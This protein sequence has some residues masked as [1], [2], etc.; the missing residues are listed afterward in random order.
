M[1]VRRGLALCMDLVRKKQFPLST[2]GP[3]IHNNDVI[4]ELQALG[5]SSVKNADDL[6]KD[7]HILI[8]SHGV[9]P[10]QRKELQDKGLNI[11][12][13]TCPKVAKVQ[14][15]IKGHV[16]KGYHVVI[17]GDHGHA[18]T[19]GLIGYANDCGVIIP[20]REEAETF[21]KSKD[22]NTPICVVAQTTQ[23]LHFF[24]ELCDLLKTK[25]N[26]LVVINTICD[27]T[28]GRQEEIRKLADDFD[29][30][31]VVGS[32]H[33]AN[34]TR[35]YEIAK[36]TGKIAHHVENADELEGEVI[37][38]DER[39][40]ITAGASTPLWIIYDIKNRLSRDSFFN[41]VVNITG[42]KYLFL[43]LFMLSALFAIFTSNYMD[44]LLLLS[45]GLVSRGVFALFNMK[46]DILKV[47]NNKL[48]LFFGFAILFS[49]LFF[50]SFNLIYL[51]FYYAALISM[52]YKYS[53]I[54]RDVIYTLCSLV[55][56][57]FP[58][59]L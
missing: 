35:L 43:A 53:T 46:T 45:V 39:V 58:I 56:F 19:I 20:S 10:T 18:E 47:D 41:K 44:L 8:R 49:L 40:L 57:L 17:I 32:K 48:L 34:T 15:I 55:F 24:E 9:S 26:K 7:E 37:G 16:R 22:A 50:L 14:G 3:I 51:L 29:R 38:H 52:V 1:G 12:D 25:F 30:F 27:A 33:S 21:M 36:S 2:L 42:S 11:C 23:E 31:I 5:V 54:G 28:R 4:K 13:A 6:N 59:L